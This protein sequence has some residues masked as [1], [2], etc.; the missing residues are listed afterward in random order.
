[1][2]VKKKTSE[3]G[4]DNQ[5]CG[6]CSGGTTIAENQQGTINN[7]GMIG[8]GV[9]IVPAEGMIPCP[10]ES[11]VAAVAKVCYHVGVL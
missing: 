5:L 2:N 9:L 7:A 4:T 6:T 10:I 11:L 1:M 8:G 3:A